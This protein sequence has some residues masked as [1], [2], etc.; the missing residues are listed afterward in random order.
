MCKCGVKQEQKIIELAL[1][2]SIA[3]L[4]LKESQDEQCHCHNAS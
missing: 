3:A 1:T 4:D 2:N